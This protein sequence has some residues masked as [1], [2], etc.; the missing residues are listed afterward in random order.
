MDT[1][2]FYS[3]FDSIYAVLQF[4][5]DDFISGLPIPEYGVR[6]TLLNDRRLKADYLNHLKRHKKPIWS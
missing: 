2:N 6:E 5:E 3:H 4:I 1:Y